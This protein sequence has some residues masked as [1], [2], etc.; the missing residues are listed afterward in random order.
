MQ[1]SVDRRPVASR[2]VFG[3]MLIVFGAAA[4]AARAAGLNIVEAVG[5]LGW[6][7][8]VVIPGVVLLGAALV[9][10]R[11]NGIG[12]A[13]AG[14]IVTT[15]GLLLLYQ[16][17]T[18]HWASWA[19]AWALIPAA[20]G[21][22]QIGYGAFAGRHDM[23]TRGFWMAGISGVLFAVGAW[24]FEGLYA[25]QSRVTA[26]EGWPLVLII[27]GGLIALRGLA[28]PSWTRERRVDRGGTGP[29]VHE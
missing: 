10:G 3:I 17:R 28:G 11:P 15:V 25:G 20:A 13:I 8:L 5:P 18:D 23:V 26:T 24:F 9:P 29:A 7:F 16:A 27:L 22:A 2:I 12:F 19:Y 4:L 6:P 1:Q 21:L 14:A